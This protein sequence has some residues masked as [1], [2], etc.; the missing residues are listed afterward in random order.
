[1][2]VQSKDSIQPL[3]KTS[4]IINICFSLN[5]LGLIP[6]EKKANTNSLFGRVSYHQWRSAEVKRG[7]GECRQSTECAIKPAILSAQGGF[8]PM[9]KLLKPTSL[10]R[11]RKQRICMVITTSHLWNTA[12]ERRGTTLA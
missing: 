4:S 12:G 8:N 3:F 10:K 1:M 5:S 9:G 2:W 11:E 7:K 6:R